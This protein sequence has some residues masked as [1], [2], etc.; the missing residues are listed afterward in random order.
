MGAH[1]RL[2][3]SQKSLNTLKTSVFPLM[4]PPH[5]SLVGA[6]ITPI[7]RIATENWM[8]PVTIANFA[9]PAVPISYRESEVL[10][11]DFVEGTLRGKAGVSCSVLSYN[12]DIRITLAAESCVFTRDELRA[13][14]NH[15]YQEL[16]CLQDLPEIPEIRV[17]L[18]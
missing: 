17:T 6:Q 14:M 15:V 16:E 1:Q 10:S 12:G 2:Q 7:V 4:V 13:C 5:Q 9:G 18:V 3:E 11:A 8:F